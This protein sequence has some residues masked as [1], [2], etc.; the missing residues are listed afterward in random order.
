M[1]TPN[2][3]GLTYDSILKKKDPILLSFLKKAEIS[4]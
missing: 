3:M 2:M 1:V 4:K